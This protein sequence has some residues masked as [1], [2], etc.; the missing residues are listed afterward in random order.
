M[1]EIV[2]ALQK[3]CEQEVSCSIGYSVLGGPMMGDDAAQFERALGQ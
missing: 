3:F 1:T 2:K